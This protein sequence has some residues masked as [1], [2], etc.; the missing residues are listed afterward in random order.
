MKLTVIIYPKNDIERVDAALMANE[1]AGTWIETSTEVKFTLET[2]SKEEMLNAISKV[3]H[4]CSRSI[5]Y[6]SSK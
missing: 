4:Y 3:E 2:E 5:F 6:S 1:I